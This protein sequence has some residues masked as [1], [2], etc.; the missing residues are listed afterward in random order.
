MRKE[1]LGNVLRFSQ[2]FAVYVACKVAGRMAAASQLAVGQQVVVVE[3]HQSP[4]GIL[5]ALVSLHQVLTVGQRVSNL[6]ILLFRGY[7]SSHLVTLTVQFNYL[8]KNQIFELPKSE[9]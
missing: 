8:H 9:G 6:K 5:V 3:L 2:T 4:L 7:R 1:S